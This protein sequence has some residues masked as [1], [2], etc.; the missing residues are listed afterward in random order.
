MQLGNGS[1]G[2]AIRGQDT[3][4][5]LYALP[6]FLGGNRPRTTVVVDG[7]PATYNEFVFGPAPV[8][9]VK[10]VEIFRSPQTTTQGQNSIAGAIFVYSEDPTFEPEAKV[11]LIGG[12]YRT[13]E[14]SFAASAPLSRHVAARLAGDLRY[15][16]TTSR[17]T[18]VM[19]GA[20][21][22]HEAYGM[23][24]AKLLVLPGGDDGRLLVTLAHSLSQGPQTVG[25]SAPFRERADTAPNYGIFRVRSDS[26]SAAYRQPLGGRITANLLLTAGDTSARRFAFPGFG[27]AQND[28]ADWSGEAVMNW[29]SPGGNT[30]VVGLSHAHARLRQQIDLSLLSGLMG[31]FSDWQ[32]GTGLFGEASL[33]V[34]PKTT[35]TA[36]LRYQQDRQKRVGGLVADAFSVP[37]D[38]VG[39]F[40]AWLP[41]VSLAYDLTPNWRAGVLVQKAYNPG[42]TTI[43]IDTAIPDTFAAETLWDT[44]VFVRGSAAGG[45]LLLTANAFNYAMR[46]A[47]RAEPIIITTPTGRR[48]GFAN[49]FNVPRAY[50]RGLEAE[51]DWRPDGRLTLRGSVGLLETR[52]TATDTESAIYQGHQFDRSPRLTATLAVDWQMPRGPRLSAQVRHHDSYFSDNANKPELSIGSATIIDARAEYDL[53]LVAV[54]VQARN[55]FDRFAMRSLSTAVSGEAEDPRRISAGI[56]A[57]F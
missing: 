15:N 25:V 38:Y 35:L 43:R 21:P 19:A 39:I 44:E 53:G 37:I 4:G 56:E 54:F 33:A 12:D 42:G 10:R 49:L 5:P 17:I 23:L 55:V 13:G 28:G 9:D 22:N 30:A 6:A 26:I 7:R 40:H 20:D 50:S 46:N 57:R 27:E 8:W 14:A 41:K 47:Q 2:P 32:D 34:A 11:R 48:A 29:K 24:R 3:T 1:Q 45:Q 36:G 31:S 18:D 51:A 16:R 52:I